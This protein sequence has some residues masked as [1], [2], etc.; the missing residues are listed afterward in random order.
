[1][2][3]LINTMQR[4]LK[5]SNHLEVCAALISVCR[6]VNNEMIPAILPTVI[7]LLSHA[8]ESVRKK[9]I[10]ALHRFWKIDPA[11]VA[12]SKD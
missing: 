3:L 10:M 9:A 6:L 7:Q 4:D 11:S 5:S 1:M 2:L 12:D 8:H